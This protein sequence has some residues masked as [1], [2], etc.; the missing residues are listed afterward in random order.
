MKQVEIFFRDLSKKKQ[1]E[2]C[3]AAR[4]DWGEANNWDICPLTV[5]DFEEDK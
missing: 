5:I 4:V 1:E 3:E 2:V